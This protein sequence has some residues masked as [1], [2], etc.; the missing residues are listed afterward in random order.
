MKAHHIFQ[1][2]RDLAL[3]I[4]AYCPN[5]FCGHRK[6][7]FHS[8]NNNLKLYVRWP[9]EYQH[10]WTT[11]MLEVSEILPCF[12]PDCL[13]PIRIDHLKF[14]DWVI[15]RG[16]L[17]CITQ[18]YDPEVNQASAHDTEISISFDTGAYVLGIPNLTKKHYYHL[19][20]H[21]S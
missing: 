9:F 11:T 16:H 1:L 3:Q 6:T 4:I 17:C 18:D 5:C 15:I 21:G 10:L 14:G 20:H 12:E 19:T 8:W 7:T 2:P 13:K